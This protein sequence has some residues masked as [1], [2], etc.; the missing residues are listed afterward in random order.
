MHIHCRI[1]VSSMRPPALRAA[2]ISVTEQQIAAVD[3][4][5]VFG[6]LGPADRP[7]IAA[8]Q[9]ILPQRLDIDTLRY[10]RER[11]DVQRILGAIEF[12]EETR[13]AVT[14]TRDDRNPIGLVEHVGRA[15]VHANIARRAALCIDDLDH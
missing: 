5:M 9:R 15:D 3:V 7:A 11:R 1:P 4:A 14:L 2:W 6:F 12:A 10:L 8:E 13:L